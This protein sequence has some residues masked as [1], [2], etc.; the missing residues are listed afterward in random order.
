VEI[1]RSKIFEKFSEI[2]F[3]FSTKNGLNRKEPFFFNLSF[4]VGDDEN[5]VK[6][7][8][9]A[10]ANQL[11]LDISQIAFQRQIHSNIITVV[12]KPGIIGESDAMITNKKNIGLAISSADCTPIFIYEKEKKIIAAVHSGWRGT[13]K[14][15]LSKT[16]HKMI[17]DFSCQAKNMFVYVGPSI[18][19]KNY[20]VGEEVASLFDEKYLLRI[21]GKIY[22]DVLQANIDQLL[23]NKIPQTQIEISSLCSFEEKDLLHSYRR[24]GKNSGRALGII[25]M[26]D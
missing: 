17:D 10:F 25:A 9:I 11:G 22:L 7:N 12:E 14:K 4:T 19:Q 23:A 6:E 18:H 13:E 5:I 20:E 16:I 1:L 2:I 24:D 21:D 8:R 26:K 3:G 15:I